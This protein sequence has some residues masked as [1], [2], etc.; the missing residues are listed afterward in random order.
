MHAVAADGLGVIV[1]DLIS[2]IEQVQAGINLIERTIAR[3]TSLGD[4]DATNVIVLDDVTP[5]YL[6]ASY[7]LHACNASLDMAAQ[8]LHD[9]QASARR[10]IRLAARGRH[11]GR[12][13]ASKFFCVAKAS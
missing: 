4:H 3:E 5:Q 1:P 6:K 10:P 9:A 2:L 13:I 12:C 8:S 11:L 7:A